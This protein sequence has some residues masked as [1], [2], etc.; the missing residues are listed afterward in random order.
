MA[1]FHQ[2]GYIPGTVL[3]FNLVPFPGSNVIQYIDPFLS[4]NPVLLFLSYSEKVGLDFAVNK[5]IFP[6]GSYFFSAY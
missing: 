4:P 2:F 1:K 6:P 3:Q 5:P